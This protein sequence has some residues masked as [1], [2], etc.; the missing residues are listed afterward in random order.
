MSHGGDWT[1]VECALQTMQPVKV[2]GHSW[3]GIWRNKAKISRISKCF[4]G[5][6]LSIVSTAGRMSW[7][8]D[9]DVMKYPG[10]E[11]LSK[12]KGDYVEL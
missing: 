8:V 4:K 11:R 3:D 7:G 6:E 10:R 5:R 1:R 2:T 12:Q 9:R